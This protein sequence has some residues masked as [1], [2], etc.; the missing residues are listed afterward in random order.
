MHE[1]PKPSY[2]LESSTFPS[3]FALTLSKAQEQKSV[4]LLLLLFQNPYFHLLGKKTVHSYTGMIDF[5]VSL[6]KIKVSDVRAAKHH[7]LLN[8]CL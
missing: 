3:T 8:S 5:G 2:M 4:T 6:H 1:T 7:V